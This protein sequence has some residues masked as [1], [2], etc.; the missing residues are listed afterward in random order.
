MAGR[1]FLPK[2]VSVFRDRHGKERYRFRRAGFPSRYFK[3][4]FGSEEFRQEYRVFNDPAA[5]ADAMNAQTERKYLPGSIGKL[6]ADYTKVPT[7]MGPSPETQHKVRRILERFAAGREDRLVRDLRFD[8]VDAIIA[9]ARV[10]AKDENGRSVGGVEAARK[11]RKELRRLFAFAKRQKL[12]T[13]NPVEDSEPVRVPPAERSDGFHC[14]TEEEIAKYRDRWPLGTK[15]RLAMEIILW[16]DQRKVDAVHLGPQHIRNNQ[17]RVRQSKT[18]KRLTL[19]LV[20]QLKAA[21]DAMPP[22][23]NLCY[24]MTTWGKPF[25]VNGFGNWFR[26]QCDA[27]GLPHCASHGLRKA[28]LR[29]MAERKLTNTSMKSVSGHSKDDELN[30]YIATA[31]QEDLADDALKA[32]S[33]WELSNQSTWLDTKGG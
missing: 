13:E 18:G 29:R 15:Q 4:E 12:I 22:T 16:T 32:V 14:W 5:L 25:S 31:D 33:T 17:I 7:R 26:K 19:P 24:I 30:R 6:I 10:K 11:L 8:H 1:R 20:P 28:T 9:R 27:A 2:H 3:A 23:E 21:I